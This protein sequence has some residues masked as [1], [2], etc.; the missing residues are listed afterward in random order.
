M[1]SLLPLVNGRVYVE[2]FGV[3]N[4]IRAENYDALKMALFDEILP[5]PNFDAPFAL[6]PR[7]FEPFGRPVI[8]CGHRR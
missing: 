5:L 6:E 3:V 1:S 2:P 4:A 7:Q 8:D